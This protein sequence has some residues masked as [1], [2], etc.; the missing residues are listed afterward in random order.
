MYP[1][2]Y[3]RMRPIP[4]DQ[5]QYAFGRSITELL[6]ITDSKEHYKEKHMNRLIISFYDNFGA[7][8]GAVEELVDKGFRQNAISLIVHKAV[9]D[10]IWEGDRAKSWFSISQPCT[11]QHPAIGP[12]L[13]SGFFAGDFHPG[14]TGQNSLVRVLEKHLV[15]RVDAHA[16]TEGV[17][18]K[19]TLVI[20]KAESTNSNKA[21]FILDRY[22]PV[23]IQCLEEQW[24]KTGWTH[25]DDTARP[26]MNNG[27]NWP[28]CITS[29]PA[30]ELLD[31]GVLKNWPQ[32]IVRRSPDIR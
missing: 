20:V 29:F 26:L 5:A 1:P 25:F 32:N 17:R 8:H 10:R 12:V 27:L 22:R 9:H 7:A 6:N 3:V 2:D 28:N 19:G 16:Y 21:L 18:R 30:D 31:D 15:P 4:L 23:D 13:V 24:R 14:E 11:I